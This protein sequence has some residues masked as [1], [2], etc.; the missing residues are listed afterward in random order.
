[1]VLRIPSLKIRRTHQPWL[2]KLHLV[3]YSMLGVHLNSVCGLEVCSSQ[4]RNYLQKSDPGFLLPSALLPN[5]LYIKSGASKLAQ[6]E[7]YIKFSFG[8]YTYSFV[9]IQPCSFIYVLSCFHSTK[10][11]TFWFTSQKY[12]LCR[13]LKGKFHDFVSRPST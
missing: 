7:N 5:L 6:T 2:R 9:E 13:P 12:L 4:I 10:A 3:M 1:M 8:V 11:E